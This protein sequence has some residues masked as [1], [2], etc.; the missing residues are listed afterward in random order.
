MPCHALLFGELEFV[1]TR[2]Q[3]ASEERIQIKADRTETTDENPDPMPRA[4]FA[5]HP[6]KPSTNDILSSLAKRMY[7]RSESIV[8]LHLCPCNQIIRSIAHPAVRPH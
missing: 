3:R 4:P 5:M 2:D 6:I 1:I 7:D 8:A